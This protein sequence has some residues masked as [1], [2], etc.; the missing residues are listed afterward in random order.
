MQGVGVVVGNCSFPHGA[1][2]RVLPPRECCSVIFG[3]VKGAK[4]F[5]TAHHMVLEQALAARAGE[6]PEAIASTLKLSDVLKSDPSAAGGAGGEVAQVVDVEALRGFGRVLRSHVVWLELPETIVN[7][8]PLP[9]LQGLNA[10]HKEAISGLVHEECATRL[11][12]IGI[13]PPPNA[14]AA[15]GGKRRRRR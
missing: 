9:R 12:T 11:R 2:A 1:K 10:N 7:G 5:E 6:R 3:V 4:C 8:G 15:R 14:R 13:E